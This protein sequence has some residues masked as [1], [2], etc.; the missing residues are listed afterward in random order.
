MD[1]NNI[2]KIIRADLYRYY[3]EISNK[4][5]RKCFFTNPGFKFAYFLRK[6]SFYRGKGPKSIFFKLFY[7]AYSLKYGFDIDYTCSKEK[8]YI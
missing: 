4:I 5:F 3:G 2:N 8:D 7:K 1:K 6:C